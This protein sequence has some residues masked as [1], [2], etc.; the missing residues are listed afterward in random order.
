MSNWTS[1]FVLCLSQSYLTDP[2]DFCRSKAVSKALNENAK[3]LQRPLVS[4]NDSILRNRNKN[5]K[6]RLQKA[7]E[8]YKL[9]NVYSEEELG[10]IHTEVMKHTAY[11]IYGQNADLRFVNWSYD[12]YHLFVSGWYI[13]V[14]YDKSECDQVYYSLIL[15][16]HKHSKEV[17]EYFV[18]TMKNSGITTVYHSGGYWTP[19]YPDRYKK[20][21]EPY[22]GSR[23]TT[24]F[25]RWY[26]KHTTDDKFPRD[27][28]TIG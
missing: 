19:R 4:M 20:P 26:Q 12:F 10:R 1:E 24:R 15:D 16:D 17:Q 22:F 11:D 9:P 25:I 28:V 21:S 3:D 8:K 6:L 27:M 14:Q 23:D 7:A 18:E 2:L 13:P 5:E